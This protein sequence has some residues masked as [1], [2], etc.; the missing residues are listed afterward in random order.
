[1]SS[2]DATFGRLLRHAAPLVMAPPG[3]LPNGGPQLRGLVRVGDEKA[4]VFY[5]PDT[6]MTHGTGFEFEL[7][8]GDGELD[9]DAA[10]EW[11]R[12]AASSLD[13]WQSAP[14]VPTFRDSHGNLI[15]SALD[16]GFDSTRGLAWYDQNL[17]G[18]LSIF[19]HGGGF[20]W[21]ED[22]YSCAGFMLVGDGRCR[23]YIRLT[24]S[25]EMYGLDLPLVESRGGIRPGSG[26]TFPQEVA[27]VIRTNTLVAQPRV[28]ANDDYAPV[29]F[30]M[31][32][33]IG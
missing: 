27:S 29:V 20:P 24:A 11:M 15:V 19:I 8:A 12:V 31:T 28:E 25:G 30:D 17:F 7:L 14:D 22:V 3:S 33:W 13:S 2:V 4:R 18:M 1:M 21:F 23:V 5:C 32:R 9:V 26:G 10:V 16:A 6:T